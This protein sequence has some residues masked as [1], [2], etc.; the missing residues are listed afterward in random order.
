MQVYELVNFLSERASKQAGHFFLS[1]FF[2]KSDIQPGFLNCMIGC[3]HF[4]FVSNPSF[5]ATIE[6]GQFP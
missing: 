2:F 6:E 4:S 5:W 3:I 1:F